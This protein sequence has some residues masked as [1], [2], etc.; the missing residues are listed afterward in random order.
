MKKLEVLLKDLEIL[1]P[2]YIDLSLSRIN[3]LLKKIDNPHLDLRLCIHIAGTNGKGSIL[4]F[5]KNIMIKSGYKVHAYISPHLEKINERFTISNNIITDKKLFETLNF[6]KKININQK[7]TF[8]EI[9]TAAAFYLFHNNKADFLLIETGLGGRLDA[10]NVIKDN[11][12]SIISPISLDH[13]EYLGKSLNKITREKLG[14]I[15]KSSI[16]ISAKQKR[17]IQ[18][19]II[20]YSLKNQ[21]KIFYYGKDW[22][23]KKINKKN[24]YIKKNKKI[25]KYKMPSLLGDHQVYNASTSIQTINILESKGYSF[26]RKNINDGLISTKW[27]CRLEVLK[28]KSPIIILDGAHNI[29]GAKS[30]RKFIIKSKHKT[31]IILAMLNSKDIK[32]YLKILKNSIACV[33]AINIPNEKNSFSKFEIKKACDNLDIICLV[34]KNIAKAIYNLKNIQQADQVIITGSLYLVGKV[35]KLLNN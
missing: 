30:L 33:I 9:T 25:N 1:H 28:K 15:K 24:F 2:K 14:I 17:N 21:N 18:E 11:Y 22:T 8:Y 20:K 5:I 34:E 3:K 31:W 6:I 35:K 10:T 32:S 4:N 19:K 27:P 12:I 16:I 13:Q 7:I 29:D 26:N 23:I